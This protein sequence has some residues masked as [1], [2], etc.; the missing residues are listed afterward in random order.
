MRR[1]VK[2]GGPSSSTKRLLSFGPSSGLIPLKS[3]PRISSPCSFFAFLG[4]PFC[5]PLTRQKRYIF[6]VGVPI[7]IWRT[8]FQFPQLRAKGGHQKPSPRSPLG[9]APRLPEAFGFLNLAL[10]SKDRDKAR[11]PKRGGL[12][13]RGPFSSHMLLLAVFV[14]L[15]V[16]GF[17]GF[18]CVCVLWVCSYSLL[19][20]FVS[21]VRFCWGSVYFV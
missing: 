7:P 2:S 19:S 15:G 5:F 17:G 9:S 11:A 1:H 10:V 4:V 20:L 8:C 3:F 21:V 13:L 12:R 18:V 6:L 16:C 14:F